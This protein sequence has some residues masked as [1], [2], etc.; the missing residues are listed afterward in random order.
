MLETEPS[1]NSFPQLPVR[2]GEP[3]FVWFAR[4]AD[5]AAYGRHVAAFDPHREL[6]VALKRRFGATAEVWRLSPTSRSRPL[7]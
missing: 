4:F 3:C 5:M 7:G 6:R 1:P 2:E